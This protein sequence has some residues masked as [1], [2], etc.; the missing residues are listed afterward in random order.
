MPEITGFGRVARWLLTKLLSID[1][2]D[3]IIR[4]AAFDAAL[5][6]NTESDRL[7]VEVSFYFGRFRRN[8]RSPPDIA[9]TTIRNLFAQ[10]GHT[11]IFGRCGNCVL[12]PIMCH[13]LTSG[14][15]RG[16]EAPQCF[17]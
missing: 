16:G 6:N 12:K 11:V 2:V 4:T 9:R 7:R 14:D 5:S 3:E 17:L 10:F 13:H 15:E 8:R 1:L